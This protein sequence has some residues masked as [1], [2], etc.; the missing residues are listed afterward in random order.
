MVFMSRRLFRIVCR[1]QTGYRID[2]ACHVLAPDLRTPQPTVV[3]FL[4]FK[5]PFGSVDRAVLCMYVHSMLFTKGN[6]PTE[7]FSQTY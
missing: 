6:H 7:E 5:A 4:D 2:V 1:N 3:A